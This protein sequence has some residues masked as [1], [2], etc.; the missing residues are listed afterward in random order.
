MKVMGCCPILHTLLKVN[1][2]IFADE[3]DVGCKM[4]E[5]ESKQR[6]SPVFSLNE[7]RNGAA[8]RTVDG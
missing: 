6:N 3:L 2:T 5:K 1:L 8:T 4:W 7:T